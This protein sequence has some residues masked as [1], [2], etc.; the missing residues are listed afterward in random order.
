MGTLK[1][2]QNRIISLHVYSGFHPGTLDLTTIIIVR[3]V[4][5]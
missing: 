3:G 4:I 2:N 5:Y 1:Q